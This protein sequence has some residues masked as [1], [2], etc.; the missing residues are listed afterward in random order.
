MEDGDYIKDN[1]LNIREVENEG[2]IDDSQSVISKTIVN[3]FSNRNEFMTFLSNN[4]G[5]IVIRFSAT[6]CKPCRT[7]KPIVDCFFASSPSCVTCVDVDIDENMDIY[8][9]LKSK[10]MIY[11]VP[12]LMC[13]S[14]VNKSYIPDF[15]ISGGSPEDLDKFFKTCG[16]LAIKYTNPSNLRQKKDF[17]LV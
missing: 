5:M 6:W 7:I 3:G 8:S 17:T 12:T 15:S 16:K 4:T 13:Y 10:K 14:S 11:G 9:F 2:Q 1:R